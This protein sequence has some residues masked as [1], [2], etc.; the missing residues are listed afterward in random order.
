MANPGERQGEVVQRGS[1]DEASATEL[2]MDEGLGPRRSDKQ[3]GGIHDA[4][5]DHGEPRPEQRTKP[6]LWRK[7][8]HV[9][10]V[11]S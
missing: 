4:N 3:I 7:W 10:N 6:K 5:S 8:V 9:G 11:C 1:E 2:V